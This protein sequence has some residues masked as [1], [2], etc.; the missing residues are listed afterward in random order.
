MVNK[1]EIVKV[2]K[3]ID[4]EITKYKNPI[5]TEIGKK[6]NDP[7]KVLISCLISLRTKDDVTAKA[8]KRPNSIART[9]TIRVAN[10]GLK[11]MYTNNNIL[12]YR[13]L[14]ALDDRTSDICKS[15]NGRVFLT[16]DGI[17]GTNM[18]PMHVNCRST[19]VGLIE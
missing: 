12:S 8:S 5:V 4:K 2:I 13:Y 1:K 15:L 14:A 10:E 9:E 16:K 11:D 7:Y 17:P 18:P 6:F 3:L 19:I